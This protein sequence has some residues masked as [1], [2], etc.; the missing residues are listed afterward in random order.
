MKKSRLSSSHTV[1]SLSR[2]R[3]RRVTEGGARNLSTRGQPWSGSATP[4]VRRDAMVVNLPV[5]AAGPRW[6]WVATLVHPWPRKSSLALTAPSTSVAD[7][8]SRVDPH[9]RHQLLPPQQRMAPQADHGCVR[10]R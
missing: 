8:S 9:D 5:R 3:R 2:G 6:W 10:E 1:V 4:R 7:A